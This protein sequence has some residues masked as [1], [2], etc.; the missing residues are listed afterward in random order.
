MLACFLRTE[1]LA[2]RSVCDAPEKTEGAISE[3]SARA[4]SSV[5][6]GLRAS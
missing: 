2:R 6:P 1:A 3:A 4:A 5:M